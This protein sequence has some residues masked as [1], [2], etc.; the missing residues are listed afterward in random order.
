ML[1][2]YE[3]L[4]FQVTNLKQQLNLKQPLINP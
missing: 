1:N 4:M 2:E 3:K